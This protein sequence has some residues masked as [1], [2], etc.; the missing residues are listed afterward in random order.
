MYLNVAAGT[1]PSCY[2]I[3]LL[4]SYLHN[5]QQPTQQ[6]SARLGIYIKYTDTDA[7]Y[8]HRNGINQFC[9]EKCFTYFL[10]QRDLQSFCK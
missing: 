2:L 9:S 6:L 4:A 10:M 5:K 1:G 8:K 3:A 7:A